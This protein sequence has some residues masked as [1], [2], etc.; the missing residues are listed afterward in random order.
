[1]FIMKK[2][3]DAHESGTNVQS[4]R[5]SLISE[6]PCSDTQITNQQLLLHFQLH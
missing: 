4:L 6:E 1:M 2:Q 5:S 3:L